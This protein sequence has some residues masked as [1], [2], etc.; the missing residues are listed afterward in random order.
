VLTLLKQLI[1]TPS[2]DKDGAN[3]LIHFCEEWLVQREI[4]CRMVENQGYKSLIAEVG[5]GEKT[6]VLNGHLDVVGAKA[7]QFRPYEADGRIYGR[8]AADMKAGIAAFMSVMASLR[9]RPP[10]CRVQLQLV[11]D[12]ETGGSCTN[13]LAANGWRGDF[14]ICA[15]PTQ[16]GIAVQ[17]KGILQIQLGIA[18]HAA[19]GSRPW[20][21]KNAILRAHDIYQ[22]ITGLPFMTEKS[23]FYDGPSVNLAKLT[24]G[25]V[26]NKVPDRCSMWLDIRYL[27]EQQAEEVL[28]QVAGVIPDITVH[29]IGEPVRTRADDPYVLRLAEIIK[30]QM[31]VPARIFG[32]H[33]SADTRFFSK[34]E[35]PAVEFG[36]CGGNWHGDDEYVELESVERYVEILQEFIACFAQ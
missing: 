18:G 34:Y 16:L 23:M 15:E 13:Y 30:R 28:R 25:D 10:A 31:K 27:P 3:A 12:E 6:L 29:A 17:A 14:V 36:P 9:N 8:G 19:H 21:G 33:G 22:K 5:E 32:Q 7:S 20:E 1:T 24:G 35:I 26:Y 2:V 11:T 4:S